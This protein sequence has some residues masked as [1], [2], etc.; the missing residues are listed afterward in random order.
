MQND[1]MVLVPLEEYRELVEDA[2]RGKA[3]AEAFMANMT[4]TKYGVDMSSTVMVA[5]FRAVFPEDYQI[6]EDEQKKLAKAE[7]EEE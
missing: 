6:W 7:E 5:V 1:N 4:Q 2:M 3:L